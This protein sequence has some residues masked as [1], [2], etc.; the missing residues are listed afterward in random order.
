MDLY[1]D[2][3]VGVPREAHPHVRR[4]RRHP[5]GLPGVRCRHPGEP[6]RAA[7]GIGGARLHG[8]PGA[9]PRTHVELSR[10][11]RAIHEPLP[12]RP[13]GEGS[14]QP[15]RGV[16]PEHG[17]P[18]WGG[19]Q[20]DRGRRDPFLVRGDLDHRERARAAPDIRPRERAVCAVLIRGRA[21]PDADA[22]RILQGIV[23]VP[24]GGRMA[25]SEYDRRLRSDVGRKRLDR[26]VRE[27]HHRGDAHHRGPGARARLGLLSAVRP[28]IRVSRVGDVQLHGPGRGRRGSISPPTAPG[29]IAAS[30]SGISHFTR[31]PITR[32]KSSNRT[33]TTSSAH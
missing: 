14:G 10:H 2:Q 26:R 7:R 22:V 6:G 20:L 13:P 9:A 18:R 24:R 23:A 25:P 8:P 3:C 21:V 27:Q 5:S 32:A 30:S 17:G 31:P 29:A 19:P 15:V 1:R 16:R 33:P 4:V 11:V 12:V 28:A